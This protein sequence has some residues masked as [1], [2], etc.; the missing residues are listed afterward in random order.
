MNLPRLLRSVALLLVAIS[1]H[2]ATEQTILPVCGQKLPLPS[3]MPFDKSGYELQLGQ[4]LQPECYKVLGWQHDREL[5]ITGPTSAALGGTDPHNPV[6]TTSTW[7]MHNTVYIYYSPDV[8]RWLCE[9]DAAGERHFVKECRANCPTC[10]LDGKQPIK[11]IENG[12]MI[13]KEMFNNTTEAILQDRDP[14]KLPRPGMALMVK[15]SNGSKDGWWWGAWIPE[16]TLSQQAQLDWPPPVN[17]AYPWMGFGYYC[18]NCHGSANNAEST[19]SSLHNIYGETNS[20]TNFYFQDQPPLVGAKKASALEV[21]SAHEAKNIII[22]DALPPPCPGLPDD[23]VN[24]VTR[25]R[26]DY[27]PEFLTTFRVP[28]L[29]KPTWSDAQKNLAMPPVPYDHVNSTPH[30]PPLFMTSDQCVSCHAAGATGMHFDMT[31]QQVNLPATPPATEPVNQAYSN[32]LNLAPY[33]EWVS[34]PMG[35]GGRDPI[36]F[37]QLESE[38]KLHPALGKIVPDLCLHC[39]GVM[40]QRQFCLDQFPDK[41]QGN[42]VCNNSNLLG[43]DQNS[44]PIVKRELF[45]RDIMKAIPYQATTDKQ[46][47]DSRY[48]GLARDGISC[49]TCHHIKIEETT[50]IGHTFTGDFRVGEAEQ[51]HGPFNEPKIVPMEHALGTTPVEYPDLLNSKICGSCHAV[52]LPV[53]NGN[54]PY[55]PPGASKPL[56]IIEQATYPEWVFSDY[57]DKG[58]TPKS[59]QNCHMQTSYPGFGDLSFKIAAIQE[60][61]NMPQV[62]NRRPL[63]EIDLAPRDQYGRHTLVGLNV[64]FNKFAQQF[65]DIL[66]IR[67]FDPMLVGHGVAPLE[68]TFNS[69]IQQADETTGSVD[70]TSVIIQHGNIVAN[71]EVKNE[72]GHKFPSGVGFRR[73]FIEFKVLDSKNNTIWIS[74]GTSPTGVILNANKKPV[75]GE[76]FWKDD[77]VPMTA[78]EQ[79]DWFQPHYTTIT[80]QDQAQIYQELVRDPVGKFTTSFLSLATG[81]KDNRLLPKGWTPTLKLAD[82]T[83]LGS[84]KLSAA[85]LVKRVLPELPALGGGQVNDPYYL[86]KSEGGLGGGG[87]ALTYSVSLSDLGGSMPA[88]VQATLYYQS[89]PPFFLQDRFCTTPTLADT[90]RLYFLAGHTDL[91][92]T[93]ADGWKLMVVTDTAPVHVM[94]ESSDNAGKPGGR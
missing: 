76:F 62:E 24:R 30:G 68:T 9:T 21:L 94:L 57:R 72:A 46:R 1:A 79:K 45:T 78:A 17:F 85:D 75:K 29:V 44:R 70:I 16:P 63:S 93:R 12:S 34:S 14:T 60:G 64:F 80:S 67:I 52:V 5:R 71:V 69:M 58:P 37:A 50:P 41:K 8:Y 18:V 89:I 28:Q 19:F 6:W 74:G 40:G 59:C 7:G 3:S 4:F 10:G 15:D 53:F 26:C 42:E 38:E 13:L 27:L 31:L 88:N 23:K 65:P 51:I 11:P 90:S 92:K 43:L 66:G 87:D 32:L 35:M 25:P 39:H 2:S 91:S 47:T 33:G 54:D 22:E 20:F 77:C 82:E 36:F 61:S 84:P 56:V 48:A 81:V 55:T 73:A 49:T 86:P 83:G